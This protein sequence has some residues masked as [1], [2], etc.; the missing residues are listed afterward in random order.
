LSLLTGES[1]K[2]I[3]SNALGTAAAFN[4]QNKAVLNEK[5][6]LE[7]VATTSSAIQ[8]SMGNSTTELIKSSSSS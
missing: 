5:K 8:L 2:D 3:M 4:G 7:E 1:T 6:L